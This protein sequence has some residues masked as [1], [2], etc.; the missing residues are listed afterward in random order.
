[1]AHNLNDGT[2]LLTG[3]NILLCCR[4]ALYALMSSHETLERCCSRLWNQS[5]LA[6]PKGRGQW[7]K[8]TRPAASS[9]WCP[10]PLTLRPAGSRLLH[11]QP[12][13]GQHSGQPSSAKRCKAGL[14]TV[15]TVQDWVRGTGSRKTNLLCGSTGD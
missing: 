8:S 15:N 5:H 10:R 11:A 6:F 14:S 4:R 13:A 7:E 3:T 2:V 12:C 1:M 9:A